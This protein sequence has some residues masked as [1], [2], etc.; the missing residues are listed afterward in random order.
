MATSEIQTPPGGSEPS[1]KPTPGI[2]SAEAGPAL[3]EGA[4]FLVSGVKVV[5][6]VEVAVDAGSGVVS[7]IDGL[8]EFLSDLNDAELVLFRDGLR[9]IEREIAAAT[10]FKGM[11]RRHFD[12][13]I[14]ELADAR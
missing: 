8:P 5:P 6:F 1:G 3:E 14:E 11:V 12:L 2:P 13:A 7:Q 4:R 9:Q 10:L